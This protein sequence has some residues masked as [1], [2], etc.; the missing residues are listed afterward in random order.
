LGLAGRNAQ[1]SRGKDTFD[2]SLKTKTGPLTHIN[3]AGTTGV[4]AEEE[5][6]EDDEYSNDDFD[7]EEEDE[8]ASLPASHAQPANNLRQAPDLL[9]ANSAMVPV[10]V[11]MSASLLPPLPGGGKA[12]EGQFGSGHGATSKAGRRTELKPD[13]FALNLA[14]SQQSID[15][16]FSESKT[17]LSGAMAGFPGAEPGSGNTF[18]KSKKL[19]GHHGGGNSSKHGNQRDAGEESGF[20]ASG[21]M[22]SHAFDLSESNFSM[23]KRSGS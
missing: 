13:N 18:N 23:S 22:D 8:S 4:V 11:S 15:F 19:S 14:D 9:K 16:E 12:A 7:V 17:G 3:A 1:G 20:G 10:D 21:S 6:E 2:S 5:E